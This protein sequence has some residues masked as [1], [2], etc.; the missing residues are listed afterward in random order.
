MAFTSKYSRQ[1]AIGMLSELYLPVGNGHEFLWEACDNRL[2]TGTE[3]SANIEKLASLGRTARWQAAISRWAC[4]VR[5]CSGNP[6]SLRWAFLQG[7]IYAA[8][9]S[10]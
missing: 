5:E 9:A 3:V 1:Y 10:E 7:M 8:H 6:K 2:A 4:M